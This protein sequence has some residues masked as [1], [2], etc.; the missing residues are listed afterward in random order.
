MEQ[1]KDNIRRISVD[2]W[3][4][5]VLAGGEIPVKIPL[6][7]DSMRPLIRRNRDK[8]TILPLRRRVRPG[9]IVL[10]ADSN[11]RYVVHR[12]WKCRE[13][14]VITLGDHC[15]KPDPPMSEDQL[16]GIVTNVQRNDRSI[17]VNNPVARSLGRLWMALLPLRRVY[18]T[19]KDRGDPHGTQ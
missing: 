15:R 17:P 2:Q 8:V 3:H 5:Q 9:D 18:Y 11:G 1:K 14:R 12:V 4:D 6:A 13:D 16:W 19:I 10:F 7:G